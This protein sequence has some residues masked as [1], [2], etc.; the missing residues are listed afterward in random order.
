MTA[1]LLNQTFAPAKS[2]AFAGQLLNIL[3]SSALSLMI[4]IGHTISR[5]TTTLSVRGEE[6]L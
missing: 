5:M 6:E 3:N 4:S 1:Q 2:E